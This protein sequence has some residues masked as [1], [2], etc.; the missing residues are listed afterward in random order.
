[1]VI[2]SISAD[3]TWNSSDS[4]GKLVEEYKI[5]TA[6]HPHSPIG[7]QFHPRHR[8]DVIPDHDKHHR[9]LIGTCL[10]TGHLI[11]CAQ[12]PFNILIDPSQ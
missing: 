4:L 7:K 8:A 2:R 11:R 5:A 10:E 12:V 6:I 1:M 9:P 3:P